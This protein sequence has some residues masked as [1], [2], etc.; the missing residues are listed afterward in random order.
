MDVYCIWNDQNTLQKSLIFMEK[1]ICSYLKQNTGN[2][3]GLS[4]YAG[5][6]PCK[7]I[8]LFLFYQGTQYFR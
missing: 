5:I 7:D 3:N 6:W 1:K 4:Y 8:R 2:E